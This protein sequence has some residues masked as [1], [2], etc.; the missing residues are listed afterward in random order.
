[1]A[2][3]VFDLDGTLIDSAPDIRGIANDI[4]IREGKEP[5]SLPQARDFI[6]NGASVFVRKM[7]DACGIP[8]NQHNRRHGPVTLSASR[9]TDSCASVIL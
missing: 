3:I 9:T 1:M 5:I 6:G 2:R 4:L 7:R 8:D